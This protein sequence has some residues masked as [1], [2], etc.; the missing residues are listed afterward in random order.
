MSSIT[1]LA[2]PVVVNTTVPSDVAER[3]F[4]I[5][6]ESIKGNL[7]EHVKARAMDG[8]RQLEAHNVARV[9]GG[10]AKLYEPV[11][12]KYVNDDLATKGS[13]LIVVT[14]MKLS[15]IGDNHNIECI[16][17]MA[18][19][20]RWSKEPPKPEDIEI[21]VPNIDNKT[22]DK[23]TEE[24]ILRMS[25]KDHKLIEVDRPSTDS[26][27][28]EVSCRSVKQ[29]GSEWSPGT[30]TSN[31]WSLAPGSLKFE[32]MR[33]AL[34]DKKAG[35]T[36][37]VNV[38]DGSDVITATCT[39]NKV[40]ELR[41]PEF[42][43]EYA[44]QAGFADMASLRGV[45]KNRIYAS[46]NEEIQS[47]KW[48]V[49]ILKLITDYPVELDPVPYD[50]VKNKALSMFNAAISKFNG[51][52]A[53]VAAISAAFPNKNVTDEK[54]AIEAAGEFAASELIEQC[55]VRSW[56]LK[57]EIVDGPWSIDAINTLI[58]KVKRVV[59][60]KVKIKEI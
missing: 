42:T 9:L 27:Y 15:V 19:E 16:G 2:Q 44:R 59:I 53:A 7:P 31:R 50:W 23:L 35:E 52:S 38:N 51:A 41:P 60:K 1:K 4:A 12:L 48:Q 40:L 22:I 45:V 32:D 13:G 24:E 18:P 46:V 20:V 17:Y 8:F 54:S 25:L 56:A 10:T 57:R 58:D 21:E 47:Y 3:D 29:D 43:D 30:F 34:L 39:I 26:D 14:E 6:W 5:Y 28:I 37:V 55:I 36:V 33:A 49:T 11:L